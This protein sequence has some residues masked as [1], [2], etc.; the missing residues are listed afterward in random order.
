MPQ[1]FAAGIERDIA[2]ERLQRRHQ[3]AVDRLRDAGR[4]TAGQHHPGGIDP[5][6]LRG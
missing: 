5:R 2:A 3:V 4:D 1:R 6:Q